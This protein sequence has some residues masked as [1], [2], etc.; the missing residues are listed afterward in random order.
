[1]LGESDER[2][3]MGCYF[4]GVNAASSHIFLSLW[5]QLLSCERT[6]SK[7]EK[8]GLNGKHGSKGKAIEN[9]AAAGA[10]GN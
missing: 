7:S 1:M 5:Q 10:E 2:E 9:T 4:E 8:K 6:F 3:E